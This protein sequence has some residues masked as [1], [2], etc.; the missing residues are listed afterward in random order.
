MSNINGKDRNFKLKDIAIVLVYLALVIFDVLLYLTSPQPSGGGIVERIILIT[1]CYVGL[2]DVSHAIGWSIFVP[3][4]YENYADKKQREAVWSCIERYFDEEICFIKEYSKERI[5][6]I[7]AQLGVTKKQFDKLQ[8][9]L[10]KMRGI[11]IKNYDDAR[12]KIESTL[13]CDYPIVVRQDSI[14]VNNRSYDKVK[15]FINY[16]VLAFVN[17]EYIR[18][19][20][21][22]LVFLIKNESNIEVIDKIVVPHDSNF[23]LGLEVGAILAKPVV[24]MRIDKGRIEVNKPWDGSLEEG[25][26]VIIVHDVMV[27]GDQIEHAIIRLPLTCEK[28]GVYCLIDRKEC[29]GKGA[30]EKKGVAVHSIIELGDDDIRELRGE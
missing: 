9:D 21:S 22:I 5:Q 27:T 19:L 6:Y 4:F 30:V 7:M 23:L 18:E 15:Y 12:E 20:A 3:S 10:I 24:K 29:D 8:R 25:D 28:L 17:R 26:R 11:Q 14:P 1:L 13:K 16:N 2:I